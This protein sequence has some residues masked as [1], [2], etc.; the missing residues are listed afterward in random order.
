MARKARTASIGNIVNDSNDV[1]LIGVSR[2]FCGG[3][4]EGAY[5]FSILAVLLVITT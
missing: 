5:R 3:L 1:A 4:K 2:N